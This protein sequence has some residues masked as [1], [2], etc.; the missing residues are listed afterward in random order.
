M[1]YNITVYLYRFHTIIKIINN[2]DTKSGI[3]FKKSM[4]ENI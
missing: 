2:H 3:K 4:V 1:I